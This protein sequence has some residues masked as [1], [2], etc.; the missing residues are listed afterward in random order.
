MGTSLKLSPYRCGVRQ[1][2]ALSPLLY[3]LIIE[4]LAAQLRSNPNIVGFTVE[5]E[6]IISLHYAD[7]DH[8]H[9]E[10]MFQRGH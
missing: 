5:G 6:K 9:T 4:L 2:S 10:P 3:V 8:H 1:G 7:H